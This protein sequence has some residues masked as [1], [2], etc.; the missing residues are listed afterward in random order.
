MTHIGHGRAQS[1]T[2]AQ[3][4]SAD[5]PSHLLAWH[6]RRGPCAGWSVW[7]REARR[8]VPA[9]LSCLPPN[10]NWPA[11]RTLDD[12]YCPTRFASTRPNSRAVLLELFNLLDRQIAVLRRNRHVSPISDG[13]LLH[14]EINGSAQGLKMSF[15]AAPVGSSLGHLIC[16]HPVHV[17][18]QIEFHPLPSVECCLDT[19]SPF[20]SIKEPKQDVQLIR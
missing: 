20:S 3:S 16:W 1:Q 9:T 17:G 13:Q 11:K 8:T 2:C 6:A 15:M 10:R 5:N 4:T 7:V 12:D 18:R 14:H 19:S